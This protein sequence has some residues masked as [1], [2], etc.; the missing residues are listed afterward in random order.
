M[1]KAPN[2]SICIACSD[3]IYKYILNGN[4]VEQIVDGVSCSLGNPSLKL[5]SIY[6][7]D[8]ESIIVAFD[9]G[10]ISKFFYDPE[11]EN[12][13]AVVLKVYTLEKDETLSQLINGYASQNR[14]V[15]IDCCSSCLHQSLRSVSCRSPRIQRRYQLFCQQGSLKGQNRS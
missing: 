7:C 11:M 3:G 5:S 4:N 10:T 8:D 15:K 9:E 14:D 6:C 1:C 13:K 2:D 12:T